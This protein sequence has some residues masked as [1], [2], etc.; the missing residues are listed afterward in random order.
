MKRLRHRGR[1]LEAM[2]YLMV[3]GPLVRLVP[4]A[5]LMRWI[6]IGLDPQPPMTGLSPLPLARATDAAVTAAARW[7][8]WH[9]VCLPQ[10]LAAGMMMRRR[11]FSPLLGFGVQRQP[12]GLV[13]HAWLTLKGPMGGI[14]C[15]GRMDP[16]LTPFRPAPTPEGQS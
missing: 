10:A 11:G 16:A 3:L 9:P 13:A 1:V 15:G 14:I 2:A 6:G 7:L 4:V 8:P 5:V 12:E